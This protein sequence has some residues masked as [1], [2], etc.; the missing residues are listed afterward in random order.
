MGSKGSTK[1]VNM[2]S[3]LSGLCETGSA[4]LE[5]QDLQGIL[6]IVT[7]RTQQLFDGTGAAVTFLEEGSQ[8]L[9]VAGASGT[10]R[11]I[12]GARYPIEGTLSQ[13]AIEEDRAV[14]DNDMT[15]HPFHESVDVEAGEPFTVLAVAQRGRAGAQGRRVVVG[16]AAPPGVGQEDAA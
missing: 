15:D 1:S 7:Q 2:A 5:A 13:R 6:S 16:G 11:A 14:I 9:L 12:V 8:G 10:L 4:I 3:R